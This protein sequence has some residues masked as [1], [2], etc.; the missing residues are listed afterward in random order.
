MVGIFVV[1][2]NFAQS[3]WIVADSAQPLP[4]PFISFFPPTHVHSRPDATE[5]EYVSM[6]RG[7]L[8]SFVWW[9]V[10]EQVAPVVGSLVDLAFCII[11]PSS[12]ITALRSRLLL[13]LSMMTSPLLTLRAV[14]WESISTSWPWAW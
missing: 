12:V 5:L 10:T 14:P 13:G 11:S 7:P 2:L 6:S 3:P 1:K 8:Q 4:D 9:V